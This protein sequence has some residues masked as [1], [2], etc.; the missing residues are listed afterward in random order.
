MHQS[1]VSLTQRVQDFTGTPVYTDPRVAAA[2]NKPAGPVSGQAR[3]FTSAYATYLPTGPLPAPPPPSQLFAQVVIGQP[4]GHVALPTPPFAPTSDG[5][6][7]HQHP[8]M[9]GMLPPAT[10]LPYGQSRRF[11]PKHDQDHSGLHRRAQPPRYEQHHSRYGSHHDPYATSVA[12]LASVASSGAAVATTS[13]AAASAH[14]AATGLANLARAALNSQ[15]HDNDKVYCY[16]SW[17][18]GMTSGRHPPSQQVAPTQNLF[19]FVATCLHCCA[20]GPH[21][22]NY[23]QPLYSC[24]FVLNRVDRTRA[25]SH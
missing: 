4:S 10:S 5:S 13:V 23:L 9:G 2:L 16:D 6:D 14:D 7:R 20:G 3:P 19:R 8:M 21:P 25:A 11:D 22:P 15:P 1:R 17:Q 18:P 24:T 12:I